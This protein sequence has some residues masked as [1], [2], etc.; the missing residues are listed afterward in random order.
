M[1]IGV[2]TIL[3][4]ASSGLVVLVVLAQFVRPAKTNPIVQADRSMQAH[5]KIPDD[6]AALLKRA[7]ADCHSDETVWPW[8]S[9]IAPVSWFVIDHV[10][11]GRKHLNFSEWQNEAQSI[12]TRTLDHRLE[13]ILKEVKSGGM[14]LSS[15]TLLHPEARLTDQERDRICNW[16]S[17][18]RRRIVRRLKKAGRLTLIESLC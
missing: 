17:E 13:E 8:Y 2:R 14:P 12:P 3:R 10:N 1:K 4:I 7:C 18:E 6:V 9:N 15:Y 11:H 5:V 16:A